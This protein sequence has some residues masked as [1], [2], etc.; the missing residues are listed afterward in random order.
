MK[1]WQ[2]LHQGRYH[3]SKLLLQSVVDGKVVALH[4]ALPSMLCFKCVFLNSYNPE[5]PSVRAAH[6]GA[7]CNG[8]CLPQEEETEPG[9][10][11]ARAPCS[12][13]LGWA[14]LLLSN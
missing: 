13:A 5:G 1:G 10:E 14:A 7:S 11:E 3:P 9:L 6:A 12:W 2:F 8:G 4:K